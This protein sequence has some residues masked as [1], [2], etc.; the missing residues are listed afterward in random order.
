MLLPMRCVDTIQPGMRCCSTCRAP[1][2][3]RTLPRWSPV[4]LQARKL[5]G[6]T[7]PLAADPGSIRGTYCIDVGRNVIHG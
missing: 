3:P 2:G 4:L 1:I 7:N 6:A 5:I